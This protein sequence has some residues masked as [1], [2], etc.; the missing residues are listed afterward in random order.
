MK[1]ILSTLAAVLLS[2]AISY[3]SNIPNFSGASEPSQIFS[4]LNQL[5]G[6]IQS[7]V[8]GLVANGS[9]AVASTGTSSEQTLVT[10]PIAANTLVRAGQALR[11]RCAGNHAANTDSAVVKLYFGTSSITTPAMA[12]SAETYDI[13]LL[14][15][16]NASATS[17]VYAGRGSVNTT[18]VAPVSGTNTTDDMTTALT[19]KCTT[20]TTATAA[21]ITNQLFT[22]EQI[23]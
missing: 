19:A 10:T 15:T 17:S 13:E 2:G 20:T 22:V 23:K 4:Y 7:G 14:V 1:K 6:S 11:L 3:A 12:S 18:V 5:I 8:N 16:Y 9:G 21:D